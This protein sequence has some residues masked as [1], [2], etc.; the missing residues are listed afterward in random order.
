MHPLL[1]S[2]AVLESGTELFKGLNQLGKKLNSGPQ[3]S[4][5]P[6]SIHHATVRSKVLA[7]ELNLVMLIYFYAYRI[8]IESILL[9]DII[10]I[11]LVNNLMR[12]NYLCLQ[13]VIIA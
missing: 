7:S 4:G 13:T 12:A 1:Q 5:R 9:L 11:I 2:Q 10:A 6:Q 3:S 8:V